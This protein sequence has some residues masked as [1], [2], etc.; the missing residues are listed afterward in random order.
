MADK[1]LTLIKQKEGYRSKAYWD[2]TAWRIGYGSDTMTDAAG[3][4]VSVTKGSTTTKADAQRDL[5]RRVPEFQRDGIIKYIGQEA[6]DALSPE[7]KAATTSLAY[8]YGSLGGLPSLVKALKSGD[9]NAI[10]NAIADRADDNGGINSSR[11]KAEAAMVLGHPSVPGEL[12]DDN[13]APVPMPRSAGSDARAAAAARTKLLSGGS[14]AVGLASKPAPTAPVQGLR[15]P[16][17]PTAKPSVAAAG[18]S[19]LTGG[20]SP[21]ERDERAS[22]QAKAGGANLGGAIRPA[23]SSPSIVKTTGGI[24]GTAEMPAGARPS[25]VPKPPVQGLRLPK[26]PTSSS[27]SPASSG[28][29]VVA[30]KPAAAAA[31]KPT[32]PGGLPL[33]A[34]LMS[35]P[36]YKTISVLNPAW[37]DDVGP[38]ATLADLNAFTGKPGGIAAAGAAAVGGAAKNIPKYIQ[39]RILVTPAKPIKQG[40]PAAAPVARPAAPSSGGGTTVINQLKASGLS[41]SEAYAKAASSNNSKSGTTSSGA[42]K[43]KSDGSSWAA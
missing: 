37:Q 39:K 9:V 26:A 22:A 24:A 16:V 31:P 38:G 17:A 1:T 11:R 41:S 13:A 12:G 5:E 32:T 20:M 40:A 8:N 4:V 25:I 2:K 15:L 23:A 19:V 18:S 42:P 10:G 30:P 14:T 36:V 28:A 27:G 7:A 21:T 34:P 6:W 33:P 35:K 29:A 43:T 3:N